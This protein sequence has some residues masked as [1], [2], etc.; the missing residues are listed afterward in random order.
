MRRFKVLGADRRVVM[1]VL[2]IGAIFGPLIAPYP[3]DKPNYVHQF[4][5][6]LELTA[7]YR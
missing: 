7:W 1:L 5:R 4:D 6:R 2:L 3:P